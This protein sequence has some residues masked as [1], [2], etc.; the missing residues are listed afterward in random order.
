[1]TLESIFFFTMCLTM[2]DGDDRYSDCSF[3]WYLLEDR[4][5]FDSFYDIFRS[6]SPY[7]AYMVAGFTSA[8]YKVIFVRSL[9]HDYAVLKHE[10]LH[11]KCILNKEINNSLDIEMCHWEID[12]PNLTRGS[13]MPEYGY[14]NA[15]FNPEYT[16]KMAL[17][18]KLPP[19]GTTQEYYDEQK[20]LNFRN[21]R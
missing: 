15:I 20:K 16:G 11:A 6:D 1:M 13:I 9:V 8:K 4:E 18:L 7:D 14:V 12:K 10:S 2:G 17:S 21:E 5:I 3:S 19:P